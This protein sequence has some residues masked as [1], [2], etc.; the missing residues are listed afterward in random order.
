MPLI[1]SQLKLRQLA[2][3]VRL[4]EER[5]L[6]RAAAA[7]DLG[8]PAASKLLR[9][10]E[11]SLG[12]K[13]FERHSRGMEP[14]C[15]GEI[16][17][18]HARLA[19]S[20]L[21]LAREEIAA[22]KSGLSGKVAL[23]AIMEPGT[24]LVP[25]AVARLNQRY[26]GLLVTIELDPS[27]QLVERLLSGHLDVVVGRVSDSDS[28]DELQYEPLAADEPHAIIASA[29]HPLAGRKD[30]QLESL[31]NEPWILPPAGSPV[32]DRLIAFFRQE[33]SSLPS[34]IVEA[35]SIPVVTGLLQ[36]TNRVVALPEDAV[37]LYCKAGVLTV[38]MRNLPLR[39]GSF[40]LVTHRGRPLSA[41][42][43]LT[44]SVL[45]EIAEPLYRVR[46][47][48]GATTLSQIRL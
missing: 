15:Y 18:R 31:M 44:L 46:G 28:A 21:G 34:N 40:G 20:A 47:P 22:L 23:G 13:L 14:T 39:V 16:L 43:Q 37:S 2:F 19:V 17:L 11:S 4:D 35:L 41:A 42:V 45:R 26:P 32:R 25:A 27:R 24:N 30:L 8:Q 48:V 29:Q 7:A 36:K 33:G 12:V 9:Q 1:R 38:L 3:L 6:A 5:S 10:I